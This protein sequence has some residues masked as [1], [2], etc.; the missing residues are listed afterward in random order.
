MNLSAQPVAGLAYKED[1]ISWSETSTKRKSPSKTERG[2][3]EMKFNPD[4]E[5][6]DWKKE[7]NKIGKWN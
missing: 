4:L 7:E 5:E 2:T 6:R 3:I 1:G